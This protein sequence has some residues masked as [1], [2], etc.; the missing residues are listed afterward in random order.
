MDK[1]IPKTDESAGTK[2]CKVS[3]RPIRE[4][5]NRTG[6]PLRFEHLIN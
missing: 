5:V 6:L 1:Y 2:H 3:L 4:V